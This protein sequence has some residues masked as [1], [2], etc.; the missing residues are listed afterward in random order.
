MDNNIESFKVCV[1]IRPLLEN[2]I[3]AVEIEK[4]KKPSFPDEIVISQKN[5]VINKY[6]IFYRCC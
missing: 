3:K 6:F 1:R 2:E 5:A 4:L